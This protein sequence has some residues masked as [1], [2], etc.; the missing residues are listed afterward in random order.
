MFVSQ[1]TSLNTD[2]F[3]NT[4]RNTILNTKKYN[5]VA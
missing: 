5:G 3:M 2:S 1:T 4:E